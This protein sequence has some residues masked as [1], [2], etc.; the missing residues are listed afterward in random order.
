M[1]SSSE[2]KIPFPINEACQPQLGQLFDHAKR[3]FE[4]E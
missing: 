1:I 2:V 3:Q 4:N